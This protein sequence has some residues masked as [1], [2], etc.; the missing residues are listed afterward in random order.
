MLWQNNPR[1]L[2]DKDLISLQ[3]LI[4]DMIVK[5]NQ[6]WKFAIE[7]LEYQELVTDNPISKPI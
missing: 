4:A 7:A 3:N 5:V 1:Y 2:A 6:H